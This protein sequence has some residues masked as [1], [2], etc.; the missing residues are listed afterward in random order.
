[1]V[2]VY[3]GCEMKKGDMNRACGMLGAKTNAHRVLLKNGSKRALRLPR[4]RWENN[5]ELDI[6]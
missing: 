2:Y 3:Y 1:V 6:Q 4:C 5:I